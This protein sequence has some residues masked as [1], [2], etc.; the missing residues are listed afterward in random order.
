MNLKVSIL[1]MAC[2]VLTPHLVSGAEIRVGFEDIPGLVM[3]GSP[4]ANGPSL[5]PC[6]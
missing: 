4:F 2:L 1:I 5:V 3:S 6:R